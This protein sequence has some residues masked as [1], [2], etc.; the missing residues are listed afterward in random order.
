MRTLTL[1]ALIAASLSAPALA[2]QATPGESLTSSVQIKGVPHYRYDLKA[3]ELSDY[4]GRY[5]LSNG[6][7]MSI[8]IENHRLYAQVDGEAR[9]EIVPVDHHQF[10]AKGTSTRLTFS[11]YHG[12]RTHD[13]VISEP[14]AGSDWRVSAR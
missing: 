11:Q 10:I 8:S 6:K 5:L 2:G 13:L 7:G 14:V 4:S 9:V 1:I 12:N 3:D